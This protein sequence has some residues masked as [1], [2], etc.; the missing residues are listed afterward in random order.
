MW[1]DLGES[2]NVGIAADVIQLQLLRILQRLLQP[3]LPWR[4][5]SPQLLH[6]LP[7]RRSCRYVARPPILSQDRLVSELISGP[8]VSPNWMKFNT[9]I[10][11]NPDNDPSK[12]ETDRETNSLHLIDL[13][14][15]ILLASSKSSS[16]LPKIISHKLLVQNRLNLVWL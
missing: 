16:Q 3:N 10:D 5:L 2:G 8:T 9:W 13:N 15:G 7:F 11:S 12:L 14:R 1:V 4:R 6:L